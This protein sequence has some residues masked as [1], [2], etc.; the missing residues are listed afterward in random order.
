MSTHLHWSY[1]DQDGW[2]DFIPQTGWPN[3]CGHAATGPSHPGQSPIDIQATDSVVAP[4]VSI[5]LGPGFKKPLKKLQVSNNGHSMTVIVCGRSGTT[6]EAS[7]SFGTWPKAVRG[8]NSTKADR[9]FLEQFHMH[10]GSD[11]SKGSEHLLCGQRRAAELHMVF[12]N[13]RVV[14]EDRSDPDSGTLLTVLGTMVEGGAKQDNAA[15]EP[16]LAHLSSKVK[17]QNQVGILEQ[18]IVLEDLLPEDAFSKFYTYPGSLTTP[19]CSQR[20]TWFVFENFVRVSD[21]QLQELRRLNMETAVRGEGGPAFAV[22]FVILVIAMAALTHQVLASYVPW[23][24]HS[25]VL[26]LEGVLLSMYLDSKYHIHEGMFAS[27]HNSVEMFMQIDGHALLFIFVPVLLFTESLSVDIH[28]FRKTFWQSF[29]LACPGVV[30]SAALSGVVTFYVLPYSWSWYLAMAFGSIVAV[31]DSFGVVQVLKSSGAREALTVLITS[32]SALNQGIA[33]IF[34]TLFFTLFMDWMDVSARD[35]LVFFLQVVV[36]APILGMLVGWVGYAWMWS[37]SDSHS[38]VHLVVQTCVTMFVAF[39][40]F[41]ISE[42]EYGSNGIRT[43]S[44]AALAMT[45]YIGPVLCSA[46]II[47]NFWRVLAFV[48]RALIFTIAGMISHRASTSANVTLVD[49]GYCVAL[50]VL[51]LLIRSLVVVASYPLL[52]RMGV[53]LK[54]REYGF[55]I[56]GGSRGAI[57]L[58]FAISARSALILAEEEAMGDQ[59]VFLVSGLSFLSMVLNTAATK[60]FVKLAGVESQYTCESKQEYLDHI[61][62]HVSKYAR[63]QYKEI[64]SNMRVN[65][66]EALDTLPA[67]RDLKGTEEAHPTAD[68]PSVVPTL[69]GRVVSEECPDERISSLMAK[70]NAY[71]PANPRKMR[72]LRETFMRIVRKK[73]WDLI[74]SRHLPKKSPAALKLLDSLAA[75]LSDTDME[76]HDWSLLQE[77]LPK[78][79]VLEKTVRFLDSVSPACCSWIHDWRL[80]WSVQ[81]ELDSYIAV[82]SFITA[83]HH[84]QYAVADMLGEKDTAEDV[85]LML[86]SS[87]QVRDAQLHL[88][89]IGG[90]DISIFNNSIVSELIIQRVAEFIH[91]FVHQGLITEVESKSMLRQIK[92]A[93]IAS[94]THMRKR[95]KTMKSFREE[96]MS[97]QPQRSESVLLGRTAKPGSQEEKPSQEEDGLESVI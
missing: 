49:C 62:D 32:E 39:F 3:E 47:N 17:H 38:S 6:C 31:T 54:S 80:G 33:M 78:E 11:D 25:A 82:V 34:F 79:S 2:T 95:M 8:L 5:A 9:Y 16:I 15:F 37:A 69:W 19:P 74:E 73:Y 14:P 63:T 20:V 50:F 45:R 60:V 92:A 53:G 81:H 67:L 22:L 10:W 97:P 55:V 85:T 94:H 43:T 29:L 77:E 68:A 91:Q 84:A 83:H 46:E 42:M 21:R 57:G 72:I 4:N 36:L 59:M 28:L 87:R 70:Q 1:Y 18:P 26:F 40:S 89:M 86:E 13:E 23:L 88:N 52:S 7:A 24:P 58:A 75:A 30:A 76:L 66:V 48:T 41:Y 96:S 27:V 93:G 44:V 56:L 65:A 64:C 61:A 35:F 51:M 71:P 90:E 12:V